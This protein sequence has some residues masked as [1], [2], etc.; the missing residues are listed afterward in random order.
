LLLIKIFKHGLNWK[1]LAAYLLIM[2]LAWLS[3][4][5][6]V[7]IFPLFFMVLFVYYWKHSLGTR[8]HLTLLAIC[9]GFSLGLFIIL[10]N[11]AIYEWFKLHVTRIPIEEMSK[12]DYWKRAVSP[13][14][15]KYYAKFFTV[16]YWSFWGV[17]GYVAIHIHHFWYIG[18]AIVQ[19]VSLVGLSRFALQIAAKKRRV[20]CWQVKILYLFVV[21]CVLLVIVLFARSILFLPDTPLLAQGRRLFTVIIPISVLTLFGLDVL[22]PHKYRR[23]AAISGIIGLFVLDVVCLSNYVLLNFHRLS[24]F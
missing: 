15:L 23:W 18:L 12:L 3:K 13:A 8:M 2:V 4:R 20:A 16:L 19:G 22:I 5:T 6:A 10:Q 7:F 11:E 21:S 17:F 1:R 9:L 24:L 14:S